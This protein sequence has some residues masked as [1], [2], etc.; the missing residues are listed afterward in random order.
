MHFARKFRFWVVFLMSLWLFSVSCRTDT[1][2]LS[3]LPANA[4]AGQIRSAAIE[5][6]KETL[7]ELETEGLYGVARLTYQDEIVLQ[8]AYG[9]RDREANA[10][11][12]IETGFDIGSITKA[13]TAATVLRLEERELLSLADIV[14]QFFPNVPD[15]LGAVTIAQLLDH[16]SGLPEYLGDDYDLITRQQALE[17]LFSAKLRFSPGAQEAY[18]NAGYSLL[19]L[20][21]EAAMGQPYEQVVRKTVLIPAGVPDIGYR[22]AGWANNALAVGYRR[23]QR[24]GTPLEQFW[25][26]DGPA[27][28][29]RGN[30][31]MLATTAD[32]D[33]WFSAMF[34]GQILGPEA[35]AA[36]KQ[37][38]AGSG[39]LGTRVGE[40]GGNDI[41]NA[42]YEAWPD[43]EVAFTFFTSRSSFPAE[44]VWER[45]DEAVTQLAAIA[46]E[47]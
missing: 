29:L 35:L 30:G 32:L 19:A 25:L 27:W 42:Q 38:F 8:E 18:S 9:F 43:A 46:S 4:D 13:I 15:E 21:I 36:F 34:K 41:F 3:E 31:G 5:V 47:R 37:R 20:I 44:E 2:P 1:S 26:E 12:Q 6:V 22:L 24:W 40:A 17:R 7:S 28:T 23:G 14:G 10:P 45:I 11:M 16:T 39:P 33:Q